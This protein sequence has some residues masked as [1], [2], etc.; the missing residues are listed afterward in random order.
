MNGQRRETEFDERD[1]TESESKRAE[2]CISCARRNA[3]DVISTLPDSLLCHILSFLPTPDAI[4]TSILSSR[5]RPLWTLVPILYF[6]HQDLPQ[7]THPVEDI[8]S[9]IFTLRNAGPDPAPIH[10]LCIILFD[11]W[12]PRS[13]FFS[14]TLA[15][16]KLNGDIL[17][18]PPPSSALLPSLKIMKLESVSYAN[19]DSLSTLLAACPFLRDLTLKLSPFALEYFHFNGVLNEDFVL[20]ILPNVVES[21]WHAI[22]LLLHRTPKLQILVVKPLRNYVLPAIRTDGYLKEPLTVPECLSS[23]LTTFHYNLF[24]GNE[25][26]MEFVRDFLMAAGVLK[27]MRITVKSTLDSEAKLQVHEKLSEY[28]RSSQSCQIA[29]G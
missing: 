4:R 19:R 1:R 18:N 16:L 20:E 2:N 24:S 28:Q 13:I 21:V 22:Q 29:F 23:H 17:L 7:I 8:V 15:V 9:S 12:L 27:T 6:N 10:K 14:T 25:Y 11:C 5:W 3:G 26:E